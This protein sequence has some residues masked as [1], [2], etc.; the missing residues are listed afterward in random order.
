MQVSATNDP[1]QTQPVCPA[2]QAAKPPR[3]A[4]ES[5]PT[6]LPSQILA[7]TSQCHFF[8]ML[9]V[10]AGENPTA[11]P[12]EQAKSQIIA[13]I[14]KHVPEYANGNTENDTDFDVLNLRF[15]D[16]QLS[17]LQHKDSGPTPSS[18]PLLAFALEHTD[19]NFSGR[20][21]K[22]EIILH[23][24]PNGSAKVFIGVYHGLRR[25]YVGPPLPAPSPSTPSVVR[26]LLRD[27]QIKCLHDGCKIFEEPLMID[28]S[29]RSAEIFLSLL[30]NPRRNAPVVL[31]NL[32]TPQNGGEYAWN[33]RELTKACLGSGIVVVA[34]TALDISGPFLST[35]AK[36]LGDRYTSGLTKGG[37]RV[38]QPGLNIGDPADLIRHRY[39][40]P[41]DGPEVPRWIQEGLR[42]TL[43]TSLEDTHDIFTFE[44]VQ[45]AISQAA[46][47][48][49]LAEL[50]ERVKQTM[51]VAADRAS[52]IDDK[53]AELETLVGDLQRELQKQ[54]RASA[55]LGMVKD[56]LAWQKEELTTAESLLESATKQID[57]LQRQVEEEKNKRFEAEHRGN[58]LKQRLEDRES[59]NAGDQELKIPLK[60][61]TTAHEAVSFLQKTLKP[62]VVILDNALASSSELPDSRTTDTWNYLIALHQKLWPLY[63]NETGDDTSA[64]ESGTIPNTFYQRTG[65]DYTV[66]ESSM[67]NR[68]KELMRL[69]QAEVDGELFDFSPHLKVGS[70]PSDGL[71]I[72]IAIDRSKR[73]IL[74]WHCGLHLETAGTRRM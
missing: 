51:A 45:R 65:I 31:I 53:I 27:P 64:I 4:T 35:V 32:K 12:T 21:W 10:K 34:R 8:A 47:L 36:R 57:D 67:T 56:Q 23:R 74:V 14:Q 55:E 20:R 52:S 13:W 37:V 70:K 54:Q 42:N 39:F 48:K 19:S 18:A 17:T 63:F 49:R 38:Y 44:G 28:D 30:L 41:A 50:Q 46:E 3:L 60:F 61:P 2:P 68:D 22:T 5:F 6:P 25:E 40:R 7:H 62:R 71:R 24:L 26:S 9:T 43:R 33:P 11:S 73:R 29:S 16:A 59:A 1:S 66:R 69:R 72:H 15:C 58:S